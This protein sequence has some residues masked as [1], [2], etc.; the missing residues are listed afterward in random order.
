LD[1]DWGL[2]ALAAKLCNEYEDLKSSNGLQAAF[3]QDAMNEAAVE[4]ADELHDRVR[5]LSKQAAIL[6][7]TA[8][9]L[10]CRPG[11]CS[12]SIVEKVTTIQSLHLHYAALGASIDALKAWLGAK[13]D[14]SLKSCIQRVVLTAEVA[15]GAAQE[16]LNV[17]RLLNLSPGETVLQALTQP[18]PFIAKIKVNQGKVVGIG[19]YSERQW[20]R[21]GDVEMTVEAL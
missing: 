2:V 10:G 1:G 3:L 6:G 11:E 14:E 13:K 21:I 19:I 15:P 8:E 18:M 12:D 16:L 17:R 20:P 9:L 7:G 4:T 5:W